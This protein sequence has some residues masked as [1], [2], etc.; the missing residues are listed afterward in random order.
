MAMVVF[1]IISRIEAKC[2]SW[3]VADHIPNKIVGR[4]K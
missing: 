2:F 4:G 3:T 1:H